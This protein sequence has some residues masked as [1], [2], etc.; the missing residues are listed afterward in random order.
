[1]ATVFSLVLDSAWC[2]G[3]VGCENPKSFGNRKHGNESNA[4]VREPCFAKQWRVQLLCPLTWRLVL[5]SLHGNI[6]FRICP[7]WLSS[8]S[9]SLAVRMPPLN[10]QSLTPSHHIPPPF[11]KCNGP[12]DAGKRGSIGSTLSS[13]LMSRLQK[14]TQDEQRRSTNQEAS[15]YLNACETTTMLH[16]VRKT[17]TISPIASL[18]CSPC[19][20]ASE[21]SI[22]SIASPKRR[23][24]PPISSQKLEALSL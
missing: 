18:Y 22:V 11:V 12:N 9:A 21:P 2:D 3:S 15:S 16:H 1:M 19:R 6:H 4:Y 23:W 20:L 14:A 7:A 13:L 17:P 10:P 24:H 5:L 8:Q